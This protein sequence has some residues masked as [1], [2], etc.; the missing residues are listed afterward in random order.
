MRRLNQDTIVAM[1]LLV[2]CGVCFW[3]S[4]DIRQPDYG[5]LLPSTWPRVILG[6]LSLLCFTYLVQSIRQDNT[7]PSTTPKTRP[8]SVLDWLKYWRNPLYCFGLFLAYLL[9]LPIL[10]ML[11]AGIT[12]VFLLQGLLGGWRPRQLLLHAVVAILSVGGMWSVFTFG[13]NVMLPSGI[14]LPSFS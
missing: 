7:T 11:L 3:A 12:F 14:I 2:F 9:M 1:V 6:V 4:F 8:T 10:G 5:V 13:L